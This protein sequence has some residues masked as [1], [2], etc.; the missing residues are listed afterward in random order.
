[1]KPPQI[2][3]VEK[4]PSQRAGT[5]KSFVAGLK[6]DILS[7][8]DQIQPTALQPMDSASFLERQSSEN[9]DAHPLIM[10][11]AGTSVVIGLCT[12]MMSVARTLLNASYIQKTQVCAPSCEP[13]CDNVSTPPPT[14]S[15]GS[16]RR[17][18]LCTI[19]QRRQVED[20]FSDITDN[21]LYILEYPESLVQDSS[22]PCL[23]LPVWANS[24]AKKVGINA[25]VLTG[26]SSTSFISMS[27]VE[28]DNLD[29]LLCRIHTQAQAS[30]DDNAL[31]S[32]THCRHSDTS[33]FIGMLER[34]VGY[35]NMYTLATYR[36]LSES[37]PLN[38]LVFVVD[39]EQVV[40]RLG[41]K[42]HSRFVNSRLYKTT[43]SMQSPPLTLSQRENTRGVSHTIPTGEHAQCVKP[44][45]DTHISNLSN[46]TTTGKLHNFRSIIC[47]NNLQSKRRRCQNRQCSYYHDPILGYRDNAHTD[48]QFPNN[49]MVARC[50]SFKSGDSVKKNVQSVDW[51]EAINIY[52][53]AL[54]NLLIAAVHAQ[55]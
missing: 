40:M 23:G 30:T 34:D 33:N 31:L 55:V 45:G 52:Q 14:T 7:L 15:G 46:L 50:H 44:Q 5:E 42:S 16:S 12:M 24:V 19:I 29:D 9:H 39:L 11:G 47:N 1:M 43:Q 13:T 4:V 22:V 36:T 53:S 2:Y 18:T 6:S 48:R 8:L 27:N 51:T 54:S 41:S 17:D 49:P 28:V 35:G 32:D 37:I 20:M 21:I 3:Q 38:V 10:E 26:D 25:S